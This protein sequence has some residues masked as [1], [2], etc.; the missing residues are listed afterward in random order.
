MAI[1]SENNIFNKAPFPETPGT[2]GAKKAREKAWRM[3]VC[4]G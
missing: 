2:K 4:V 3:Q 1:N